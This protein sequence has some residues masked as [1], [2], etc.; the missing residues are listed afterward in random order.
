[1]AT[2]PATAP[3]A[4]TRPGELLIASPDDAGAATQPV[5]LYRAATPGE[6]QL[7][8]N[9]AREVALRMEKKIGHRL[10]EL[11]TE[12][13]IIFT[14]WQR[15]DYAFLEDQLEEGYKVVAPYFKA[16]VHDNVFVGKLPVYMF[17]LR[18][19]LMGFAE[20][21]DGFD[22]NGV[23]GY[24]ASNAK[25]ENGHL[26]MYEPE[27]RGDTADLRRR[28]AYVLLHE[29]SHSFVHRYR[30]NV[31]LPKWLNEG[32]AEV[33]ASRQFPDVRKDAVADAR[34][35]ARSGRSLKKL[36]DARRGAVAAEDYPVARSLVEFLIARDRPKFLPFIDAIKAGARP[37]DALVKLYG[38]DYA[39]LEAAWRKAQTEGQQDASE[40]GRRAR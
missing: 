16:S 8:I 35:A 33:I 39:G 4:T 6:G 40:N 3:V 28:W 19:D 5:A 18:G 13:F 12:H 14:D 29:F 1:V 32:M 26:A 34:E 22:A 17:R 23:A 2:A 21:F 7:A 27:R 38:L 11:E 9:Q 31:R 24:F 20:E 15:S 25:S 10:R 36:L 37:E 30:S